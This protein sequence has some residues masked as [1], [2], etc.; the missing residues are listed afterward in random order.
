MRKSL[1]VSAAAALMAGLGLVAAAP[2]GAA[3]SGDTAVT[4]TITGGGLSITAPAGPVT[5]TPSGALGVTGTSVTG[6]LGSTT[7]TDT[8]GLAVG[9][10]QVL[11]TST[12]FS[13]GS[14]PANVIAATNATGYSGVVTPTGTVVV[15]GTL[16]AP[17]GSN[18][19][20][21]TGTV[22]ATATGVLGGNSAT[23]NPTV[24]V[25]IPASAVA[26]T[27]NGTVTQTVS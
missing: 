5:L 2:A 1:A 23:Y 11:M 10:W 7:V 25:A 15:P 6:Q 14:T 18:L 16:S 20:A 4:F 24:S 9:G 3:T 21:P 12:D 26:T 8:R 13:D 17:L 22:I 19:A 27:Y